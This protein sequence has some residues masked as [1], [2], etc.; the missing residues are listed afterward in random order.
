MEV[1]KFGGASTRIVSA[2]LKQEGF[3][4]CSY[5]EQLIMEGNIEVK[6][7]VIL[8]ENMTIESSDRTFPP[9]KNK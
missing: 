5:L 8:Y 4:F 9:G 6:S 2:F 1:F 7:N 3:S